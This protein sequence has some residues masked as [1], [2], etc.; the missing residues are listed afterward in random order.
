MAVYAALL[1]PGDR[2]LGMNLSHGGHL[3]H[4]AKVNLSGKIYNSFS[5]GVLVREI[6]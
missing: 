6:F 2:I 1:Q 4:G 3:T 5:Y